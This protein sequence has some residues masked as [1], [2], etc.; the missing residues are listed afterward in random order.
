MSS[1]LVPIPLPPAECQLIPIIMQLEPHKQRKCFP[2]LVHSI[3]HSPPQNNSPAWWT[4]S[5]VWRPQPPNDTGLAG[6]L[7]PEQECLLPVSFSTL[8]PRR[9]RILQ[10][11]K[12]TVLS[13][14]DTLLKSLYFLEYVD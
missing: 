8:P 1:C 12:I 2:A 5:L 3:H 13:L 6:P 14:P 4:Q 7:V 9:G 10:L 11:K